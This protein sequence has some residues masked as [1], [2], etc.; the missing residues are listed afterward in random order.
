MEIPWRGTSNCME[1]CFLIGGSLMKLKLFENVIPFNDLTLG[2]KLGD[3]NTLAGTLVNTNIDLLD[4]ITLEKNDQPLFDG[5]VVRTEKNLNGEIAFTAYEESWKL[6]RIS[7][8]IKNY[9]GWNINDLFNGKSD[10]NIKNISPNNKYV[11]VIWVSKKDEGMNAVLSGIIGE[12]KITEIISLSPSNGRKVSK[13]KWDLDEMSVTWTDIISFYLE[14]DN[15][16]ISKPNSNVYLRDSN[17]N[18]IATLTRN[19]PVCAKK[20]NYNHY[21]NGLL[22]D[23][24]Y[25]IKFNLPDL[26]KEQAQFIVDGENLLAYLRNLCAGPYFLWGTS[27]PYQTNFELKNNELIINEIKENPVMTLRQDKEIV[28]ATFSGGLENLANQI[29]CIT[30]DKVCMLKNQ[31]SINKY[32]ISEIIDESDLT[33]A[34]ADYAIANTLKEKSNPEEEFR[35]SVLGIFPVAGV[36]VRVIVPSF[37][38]DRVYIIQEVSTHLGQNDIGSS[39]LILSNNKPASR[40]K[41]PFQNVNEIQKMKQFLKRRRL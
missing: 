16:R 40:W 33:D 8:I 15:N 6:K 9:N 2:Q 4:R 18:I 35:C 22:Y 10:G 7:P 19:S 13:S 3:L 36:R 5:I 11:E 12:S 26:V 29:T 38:L 21:A 24:K 17:K 20:D 14:G 31:D 23:T 30:G 32:G 37:N 41:I 39:D 34:E 27:V 25:K 28:S 1:T